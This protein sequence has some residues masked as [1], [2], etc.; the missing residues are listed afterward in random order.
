M[1]TNFRESSD[2]GFEKDNSINFFEKHLSK[3]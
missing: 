3:K 1:T 2:V